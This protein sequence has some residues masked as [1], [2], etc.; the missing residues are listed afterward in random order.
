MIWSYCAPSQLRVDAVSRSGLLM[1]LLLNPFRYAFKHICIGG[2]AVS[3][4]STQ[5]LESKRLDSIDRMLNYD[6]CPW[7]NRWVYWMKHPLVGMTVVAMA[8]GICGMFVVPQA[9]LLCAGL[10]LVGGLGLA[11]PAITIRAVRAEVHF[12]KAWCEEQ[13][14][15]DVKVVIRNRIPFPVWGVSLNEGGENP[16]TLASF[17]RVSGWREVEFHWQFTPQQRG[18]Y[19]R[20][21]MMFETGFP[22]GVWVSRKPVVVHGELI[23]LPRPVDLDC[24]PDLRTNFAFDEILSDHRTGDS[25]DVTGTRPYRLGDSLRRVH[26]AMTA[27]VGQM[28]CTE[29]QATIQS[30]RNCYLDVSSH[31]HTGRGDGSTLEC[32]LR[33]F[34]GICQEML[35]NGMGVRAIIGA[36]C[37]VLT[38]GSASLR[39]LLMK[40]AR[41][42]ERGLDNQNCPAFNGQCD[43]AVITDRSPHVAS[44]VQVLLVADGFSTTPT[45]RIEDHSETRSETS[46]TTLVLT[47]PSSIQDNL[48]QR[49]RRVCHAA[50]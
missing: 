36:D 40:L 9:W 38:P 6:F 7:A 16:V 33:I 26:W 39:N 3:M 17:T 31:N 32:S 19:P 1:S 4:A 23:V 21:Q 12:E 35:R 47:G 45:G 48:S 27:R 13:S 34:A 37:L 49:W 18:V 14:T 43:I 41:L 8:A 10:I 24:L 11:W 22:F 42:P 2:K 50:S 15:I 28:I 29:R 5:E 25:G 30:T 46:S 20:A 44:T